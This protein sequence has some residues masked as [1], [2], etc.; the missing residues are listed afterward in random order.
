MTIPLGYEVGTGRRIEIPLR[1]TAV[2]G[3]TQE[4]GKTTTLEGLIHRS[5]LRGLAFVTKRG[6]SSFHVMNPIPP[7]FRE[8]TDWKF[9]AAILEATLSEKLKFQ[10][11][12]IMKLCQAGHGKAGKTEYS[13]P[14]PRTL[15][16]V[17]SNVTIAL[18]TARGISESVYF[19]LAEYL[20][21]IIP[22]IERLPY[23]TQLELA[24]GVN[25]MDLAA[26]DFPLQALVVRSAME[27]I[28]KREHDAVCV[29]PE[30]HKFAPKQRGSPVKLEAE[31]FI[32]ESA[33]LRNFLWIDCQDVAGV[34][35]VLLRQIGVWIFGVQRA[36]HEIERT[37]D[38]IPEGLLARRPRAGE[39]ATLSK[40]QFFVC[41][42]REMWKV[43][44]Q[45]AWMT[46][47]HAE[48]IARGEEEVETAREILKDYDRGHKHASN[49]ANVSGPARLSEERPDGAAAGISRGIDARD[50]ESEAPRPGNPAV[51]GEETEEE[52]T[53]AFKKLEIL[54]AN[55]RSNSSTARIS[56]L[57]DKESVTPAEFLAMTEEL[58][59]EHKTLIEAHDALAR[60]VKRLHYASSIQ[61]IQEIHSGGE[62]GEDEPRLSVNESSGPGTL[63]GSGGAAHKPGAVAPFLAAPGSN[64]TVIAIQNIDWIY[65]QVK[66]RAE[67]DPGI[68]ELLTRRPELRVRIERQ[69]IEADGSTLRGALG[70]LI[71]EKFFDGVRKFDEVRK[72]LIRRGFL[73]A[74]A[75]NLQ[76]SQA[77]TGLVELGF[78]TREATGYQSVAG[79]KIHIL[80]ATRKLEARA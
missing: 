32:R 43:Y 39:I 51:S 62:A 10:R 33:A 13:W 12:W 70:I 64:G 14:A 24:P 41:W 66:E 8:R 34:A 56:T 31:D 23:T 73:S 69:V 57:R 30:S 72:E 74:K 49:P 46:A 78:L 35:D 63:A 28:R 80:E 44:V 37:L 42:G 59:K 75:P 15:A 76:I 16:D 25:V 60:E 20:K 55:V 68:L 47:A 5:G 2:F 1:H 19:E 27:W 22:Q 50:R 52:M 45:P 9:V 79:M 67:K 58:L 77:L 36:K 53:S 11:S 48:A 61:S 7:Y 6:E 38:A 4:S 17:Q 29:V 26:Y 65:A 18:K 21:E 54:V 3:Q 71:S 40:G